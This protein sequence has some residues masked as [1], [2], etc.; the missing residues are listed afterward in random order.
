[1]V[2]TASPEAAV[3]ELSLER[4]AS[5]LGYW[6]ASGALSICLLAPKLRLGNASVTSLSFFG[7]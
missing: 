4:K 2:T 5:K 7:P 3:A 6:P 1:M